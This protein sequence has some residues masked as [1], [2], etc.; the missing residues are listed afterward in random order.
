[1][2]KDNL[3]SQDTFD[4]IFS[5]EDEIKKARLLIQLETKASEL[6]CKMEFKKLVAAYK[7]QQK[8]DIQVS[9]QYQQLGVIDFS[10]NGYPVMNCGSWIV[11]NDGITG[12]NTLG[13]PIRA[14]YSPIFPISVIT[15]AETGREKV[16]LAFKRRNIWK[17]IVVDKS[18][19]YSASKIIQ[20][21]EYGVQATSE[22]AKHLVKFLA[23]IESYNENA[24]EE[25]I[26]TS[27]LGWHNDLFMPYTNINML[28]DGEAR[29]QEVFESVS[30]KGSR[31]KWYELVKSIRGEKKFAISIY[32]AASFASVLI[33]PLGA[34]PF[35][36]NL[37][38][39]TGK[40]KT[41]ALMMATSI[42]ANPKTGAY[43]SDSKATM[44][45]LEMRLDLLNSL[46][47]AID[48]LS[49]I[50]N[51]KSKYSDDFSEMI[52]M[53]TSG[54]GR[55]RSNPNLGLNKSTTWQN[56]ILTNA[57]HPLSSENMQG[58]AN[59]R[60]IDV[61]MGNGYLFADGR[62]T[63]N[64]LRENYGF[65]GKEFISIINEIGLDEVK[66]IQ[67]DKL[68]QL[69]R[70][71]K[72]NELDIEQKQIIPMSIILTADTIITDYLFQDGNY[73]DIN[74]CFSI[75]KSSDSVSEEKRGYEYVMSEI[76]ININKFVPDE[77][78]SFKGEVW[79][80]IEN[81]YV[82]IQN[83]VFGLMCQRGNFNRTS[84]LSWAAGQGLLKKDSQGK[85]TVNKRIA[86]STG[87]CVVLKLPDEANIME[88]DDSGFVKVDETKQEE[89]PFN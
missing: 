85:N 15:S 1:M 71:A 64:I 84:F 42:W 83:N 51:S 78:G 57:E 10:D 48:D 46:P 53:L 81:G 24:I 22:N 69:D 79:G 17:E 30:Q 11:N 35:I 52:Y 26:S 80:I 70:I 87:R 56:S 5:E 55:E 31:D 21:A 74:E 36:V 50:Q 40:G 77:R 54:K 61:A 41:A 62:E 9:Q 2:S 88:T 67:E 63:A 72:K 23:D 14:A 44:T 25:K 34:L 28:F 60:I 38:G 47:L 12:V 49:Q 65:A 86:G 8:K 75:L 4:T 32:I 19:T 18:V 66:R 45:A 58:G 73:L 13:L 16:K 33:K 76:A 20:L 43:I 39:V 6:N 37:W 68:D 7:K 27:K 29:F 82:A 59:N 89:L 3:L